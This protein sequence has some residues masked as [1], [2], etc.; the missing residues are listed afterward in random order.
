MEHPER[1]HRDQFRHRGPFWPR[2]RGGNGG[3]LRRD[4]AD[5]LAGGVAAGVAEWR[6][7]SVTTVR[8]VFVIAALVSAGY[9]VPL[10]VAAWLF[11]PE[12]GA[13]AS[14]A[15]KARYDSRGIRLAIGMGSLLI[16]V[17]LVAGVFNAGWLTHWAWPL[18]F[19]VAGLALIWRNASPE[20]QASLR[21]LLEPLETATSLIP[22][23]NASPSTPA[24]LRLRLFGSR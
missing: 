23:S 15:S 12:A 2:Q 5:R 10:Y 18:V 13:E 19:S 11:I 1:W 14:I 24:K 16:L 22:I 21:Q 6:G 4:P 8:I 20:E 17:L 3:P 9:F 7:F